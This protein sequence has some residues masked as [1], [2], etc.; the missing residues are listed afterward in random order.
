[1]QYGRVMGDAGISL[2]PELGR[3]SL[4]RL[5]SGVGGGPGAYRALAARVGWT[6]LEE[7]LLPRQA[8]DSGRDHFAEPAP[9]HHLMERRA[10]PPLSTVRVTATE[11]APLDAS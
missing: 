5:F 6:A 10:A 4:R 8:V 1:M 11:H 9:L 2:T 3:P 7:H